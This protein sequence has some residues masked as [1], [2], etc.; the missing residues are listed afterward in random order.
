M[1]NTGSKYTI[2]RFIR[3]GKNETKKK[4]EENL[5]ER[6]RVI[7]AGPGGRGED[8][9]SRWNV[10]SGI[11]DEIRSRYWN[12]QIMT[13]KSR[14]VVMRAG[15]GQLARFS[16]LFSIFA[17]LSDTRGPMSGPV[18]TSFLVDLLLG[19]C[20]VINYA[21]YRHLLL[22]ICQGYVRVAPLKTP[23]VV[24]SVAPSNL[25]DGYFVFFVRFVRLL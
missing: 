22:S 13:R 2:K 15:P 19:L 12:H 6:L 16:R 7:R 25:E 4:K 20:S 14:G 10:R 1:Y 5:K 24:N 21:R 23:F 17:F 11:R 3:G 9:L 8:Q 18:P